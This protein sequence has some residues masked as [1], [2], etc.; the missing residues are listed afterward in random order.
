VARLHT[1]RRTTFLWI[2]NHSRTPTNVS[3]QLSENQES[4]GTVR[5]RW[6]G[7]TASV[8]DRTVTVWVDGRDGAILELR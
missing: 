8:D 4:F 3:V 6:G 1:S 2:V 5:P 7:G